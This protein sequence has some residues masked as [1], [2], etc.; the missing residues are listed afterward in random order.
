MINPILKV[1]SRCERV[2]ETC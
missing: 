1:T 2:R